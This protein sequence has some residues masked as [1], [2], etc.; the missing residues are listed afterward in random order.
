M[1]AEPSALGWMLALSVALHLA[2]VAQFGRR[3]RA[4]QRS[5]EPAPVEVALPRDAP[6]VRIEPLSE[7]APPAASSEARE[8]VA[9]VA[10]LPSPARAH[11]PRPPQPSAAAQAKAGTDTGALTR[12][13]LRVAATPELST[14]QKRRAMLALLRTWEGR[15]DPAAAERLIDQMLQQ[16]H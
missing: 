15:T 13:L 5:L 10:A 4:V 1:Q 16:E 7:P 11:K 6:A 3:P 14:E 9:S 8:V 2:V 12:T